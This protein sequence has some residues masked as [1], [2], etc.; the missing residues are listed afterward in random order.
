MAPQIDA[1]ERLLDLVIALVNT[2]GRMTKQQV[3]SSV[4]GYQDAASDDAF[5]RMFERD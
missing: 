1:S 3:R 2:S 5:E 4:A